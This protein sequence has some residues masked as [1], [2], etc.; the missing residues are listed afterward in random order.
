MPL[1]ERQSEAVSTAA[2]TVLVSAGAGSGKTRVLTERYLQLLTRRVDRVPMDRILTL[3]FTRKAAQEMRE[4]IA[5]GLEERGLGHLRPELMRAPIG[6]IHGFCE[7]VLRERALQAGIDPN[8]RVLD[9]AEAATLLEGALDEIFARFWEGTQREREEIVRL[10]LDF[11]QK[12]I[13]ETLLEIYR[14]ARTRGLSL[15][16]QP[17]APASLDAATQALY[18]AVEEL[19]T[20]P[21]TPTW[22]QGVQAASEAYAD[23]QVTIGA[24]NAFSWDFYD[25]VLA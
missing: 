25:A 7:R 11:P 24:V 22:Q 5:A 19:L 2:P 17:A 3:T 23:L 9:D 4:R 12:D 21:G 18:A 8:F 10:L 16:L 20:L 13:R 1:N 6:T 14:N 15:D